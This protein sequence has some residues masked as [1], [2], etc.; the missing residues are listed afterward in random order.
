MALR[1]G[2][3]R[4][5]QAAF[6]YIAEDAPSGYGDAA[7]RLVRALRASGISVEYQGWS[8]WDPREAGAHARPHSRDPLSTERA[9]RGA[10]TV[11]HLFPEH[12]PNVPR[13]IGSG[14][15]ISHTVWETDRLPSHWPQLLNAVDRVVVPTDW[16]R[17]VFVASGV[18][19]PV[20]VVPHVVCR[21]VP[22]D[23]GTTLHIPND[24]VV[25]Y[26]IGRWDERKKPASVI[27]AFLDAFTADDP[28]ALVVKTSP[29]AQ[30]P[31]TDPWGRRSVLSGTTLLEV[32]R[33][34]RQYPRPPLVRI[35]VEDWAPE[36]IAGLHTRGDC[37]VSLS[38]GEGWGLGAFDAAAY[39]NP[40]VM[41]GW[42]GQVAFL[43]ADRAF[44]VDYDIEPVRHWNPHAFSPEQHWAVPHHDHAVELLREVASDVRAARRRASP[45]RAR[46][47]DEFAPSRVAAALLDTVPELSGAIDMA[48]RSSPT[49]VRRTRAVRN[50]GR[51]I[52]ELRLVGLGVGPWRP[53]FDNWV[54]MAE[55]HEHRFEFLGRQ[56]AEPYVPHETKRR[57]LVDYLAELPP[58]QLVFYLDSTD[59][60]VCEGPATVL[61]RYSS[62]DRRLVMS[63]EPGRRR[64]FDVSDPIWHCGCAGAFIGEAGVIVEALRLGYDLIDWEAFGRVSDQRAMLAYVHQP[65]RRHV[66]TVDHRRVL[67]Q[68]IARVPDDEEYE[69]YEGHRVALESASNPSPTASVHFYGDNGPGY[70]RFADLY[71]LAKVPLQ[72][73][74]RFLAPSPSSRRRP[75]RPIADDT[76][77]G[78]A[79][80]VFGL[81]DEPEPFHLVH[82]LAV[83]SCLE[84]VEPAEVFVHC[85]HHPEGPYWDRIEPLVRVERVEPVR[86]VSNLDYPDPS[87]ARYSYAHHADF[88]RLD[89]L[90]KH[91]G[92]Y[93]DID[94]LFI[95]PI[96]ERLWRNQFVIGRE[97]DVPDPVLGRRRPALSN[98]FLMSAP[99]SRFLEAWRAE[100]G[101]ALD[102]TWA[103]HSCFLAKD[104]A[105]RMPNEVHVEPQRTFHEFEPSPAGLSRL[106]EGNEKNLGGIVSIHLAA[107]LWWDD[108]RRDVSRVHAGMISEEWIR[109]APVTYARMARRFLP[110]Q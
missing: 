72:P 97:A 35:E 55:R 69:E 38:H 32:A 54:E 77:P 40:V 80:F 85:H 110:D 65:A 15:L 8:A 21:P 66:A 93:A 104:L 56:I 61:E 71:G 94:T 13:P 87:V 81:R 48:A 52:D 37:Y 76:I 46:V 20:V 75:R 67:T 92:V 107:H 27:R 30:Y 1:F 19:V 101:T 95:A 63:A 25:F 28:V 6:R 50:R 57:I 98:A 51:R 23:L 7:D 9:R 78:L 86:A 2:R 39:G 59:G 83:R 90:A 53:A 84:M 82:Y 109:R 99:G 42:G 5:T 12:L 106:L 68:N 60:W 103:N 96:P 74:G 58:S 33:I 73:S 100:I 44:L 26:T 36:R 17:E 64:Q 70:N 11:A 43:E 29:F 41:T 3:R 105:S 18:T 62:Y 47:L 16:N 4:G 14:P 31:S 45:L 49:R 91:G 79:H 22:G 24:V 88:V 108:E 89:A 34:V 102:G 10:P